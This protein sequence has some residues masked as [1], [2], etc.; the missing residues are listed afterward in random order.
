MIYKIAKNDFNSSDSIEAQIIYFNYPEQSDFTPSND[1]NFDCEAIISVKNKLYIFSKNRGNAKTDLYRLPKVPG[2]YD[3]EYITTFDATGLITGATH[4]LENK[5]MLALLG[6][7]NNETALPFVWL[8]YDFTE[9]HFFNGQ[10]KKIELT[11]E[12][13]MEAIC[14]L[15]A[16]QLLFS[17]EGVGEQ[18]FTLD[19]D[20]WIP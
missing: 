17:K 4:H 7:E 14:F 19:I 5:P 13:K 3:A 16:D 9:D 10:Q 20:D 2:T 12:G 11:L 6:I 18:L 15:N 1:H 8:F